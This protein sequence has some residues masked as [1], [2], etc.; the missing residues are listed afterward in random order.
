MKKDVLNNSVWAY[1][2][3]IV[4]R[5]IEREIEKGK[6]LEKEL[7]ECIGMININA[8]NIAAWNYL[9]GWLPSIRLSDIPSTN[10]HLTK[11]P[12]P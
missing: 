9:R 10:T 5:L 1:R 2:E 8:N 4:R 11:H 6:L 7:V 3:F 12:I